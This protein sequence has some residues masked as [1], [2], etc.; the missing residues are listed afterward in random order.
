MEKFF[1]YRE[2]GGSTG[3]EIAAGIC[4]GLLSVC[5]IFM[6]LQLLAQ[7]QMSG[8]AAEATAAQLAANGETFA[9][10]YFVSMVVAVVGSLLIG[11]VAKLPLVQVSS[12]G[13]SSVLVSM[14]GIG[15]GL[16]YYNLLFLCFVSSIVYT[17]I[18]LI[19]GG[20]KLFVEALPVGVRKALPAAAGLL[21][22][23]VAAQL[24]GVFP[25]KGSSMPVYGT[26]TELAAG[27]TA[28]A[29]SGF[30][31]FGNYSYVTDQYHPVMLICAVSVL[32]AVV[33]YLLRRRSYR[34][35]LTALLGGTVVFL[36][37]SVLLT[38]VNWKNM[39][40]SFDTLWAR[41]WMVGSED[42]MQLH[43]TA[44]F[45]NLSIG[46][47]FTQGMDFTAYTEAG[48]SVVKLF[49]TG[50]LTNLMLNL[51]DAD[52]TLTAVQAECGTEEADHRLPML[53]NAVI[54]VVA[55]VLGAGPVAIG[56]ES[57]A[58]AKDRAKSGLA[59]VVAAVVLLISAFVWVVPFLLA[60]VT[61]YD[62]LFNMYG[63]YGKVLQYLTECSFSVADIV[64]VIVGVGMAVHSFAL[65]WKDLNQSAPFLTTIAAAM[66]TSNLAVGACAGVVAF[67]LVNLSKAPVVYDFEDDEE[68]ADEDETAEEGQEE[69]S[70][71]EAETDEEYEDEDDEIILVEKEPGLLETVGGATLVLAAVCLV[72]LV[73]SVL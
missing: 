25:V 52:A 51:Y 29:Q 41:L 14:V 69:T 21:M 73:L 45:K 42:S 64:M 63:H 59:S 28:V 23:G 50:I 38:C 34:P 4:M 6:N 46:A 9:Q 26:G 61:S 30:I 60:T 31:S 54:N 5:G 10:M 62:I 35:C 19:P 15:S 20:Y 58:G 44:V 3:S 53:C 48:G 72:L 40:L 32:V 12:L 43:L 57:V 68:E 1:H 2:R 24:S 13:L 22:A 67:V 16:S 70:D 66:L 33:I 17:A 55:P 18:L 27:S 11:L 37:G 7:Y 49:A 8:P 56:K 71:E 47:V 65:D 39:S 36:A